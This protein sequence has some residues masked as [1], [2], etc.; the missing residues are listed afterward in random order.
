MFT[1]AASKKALAIASIL[2]ITAIWGISFVM[3][4]NSLDTLSPLWFLGCR[5]SLASLLMALVNWKKLRSVGRKELR[6]GFYI[7][8]PLACGYATQTMGLSLTTAS[9]SA[10]ITGTYVVFIPLIA[11]VFTRKLQRRQLIIAFLAC[12]GLA[13]LSLDQQLRVNVGDWLVLLSAFCYAV[14]FLVLDHYTKAYDSLLISGLQ[15]FAAALLLLL[16]ALIFEP[17]PTAANFSPDVLRS[18]VFTA[19]FSTCLGFLVQTA[20]Q[21]VLAPA[22]ASILFTSESVFG[23]LSGVIFLQE[24]FIPR[25]LL[26]AALLVGCM[27]ASVVEPKAAIDAAPN[28]ALSSTAP[29]TDD[30]R[31]RR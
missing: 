18:L 8:L 7:G 22:Q 1:S 30:S 23:A 3:M 21:K 17:L 25:Q 14:H 12:L 31:V 26:G 19:A 20:A 5:F 27:I 4:K 15:I 28:K 9:N 6:E 24:R 29:H 10:F 16:A 13:A 11:W 2:C